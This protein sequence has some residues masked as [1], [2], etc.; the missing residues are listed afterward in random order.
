[1][2]GDGAGAG[3]GAKIRKIVEPEPKIKMTAA[4]HCSEGYKKRHLCT[5]I[6]ALSEK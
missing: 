3:A 2:T 5:Q 1:M 6:H 4:P